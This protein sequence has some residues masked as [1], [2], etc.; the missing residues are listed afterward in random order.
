LIGAVGRGLVRLVHLEFVLHLA[1]CGL[2]VAHVI[3]V[4]LSAAF[5]AGEIFALLVCLIAAG[6][7]NVNFN[8]ANMLQG[9]A[10]NNGCCG[11]DADNSQSYVIEY[12]ERGTSDTLIS[13]GQGGVGDTDV[14]DNPLYN[15]QNTSQ[16]GAHIGTC[17]RTNNLDKWLCSYEIHFGN[18]ED[19]LLYVYGSL[20]HE[21]NKVAIITV[22][23]GTG[24]YRKAFGTAL[25]WSAEDFD[26]PN[27]RWFFYL[28]F[29][30]ENTAGQFDFGYNRPQ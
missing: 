29:E 5:T 28:K 17:V 18:N 7:T 20:W 6:E 21:A 13:A 12:V 2:L 22:F 30:A 3:R 10:T 14:F 27:N 16:I 1:R 24:T 8:F 4:R 19:N 11:S 26:T 15:A 25:V 9:A 23:G